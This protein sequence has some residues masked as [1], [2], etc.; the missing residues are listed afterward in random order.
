MEPPTERE[1]SIRD[2]LEHIEQALGALSLFEDVAIM[3]GEA[4]DNC[5]ALS[6]RGGACLSAA[7]FNAKQELAKTYEW[8]EDERLRPLLVPTSNAAK[9]DGGAA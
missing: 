4:G 2:H 6:D 7:A 8:L 1:W 3:L 9:T 5:T